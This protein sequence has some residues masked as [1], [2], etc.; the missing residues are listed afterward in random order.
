MT[1]TT[2]D[3]G[4]ILDGM[5]TAGDGDRVSVGDLVD[6]SGRH[7]ILPG[8]LLVAL[9]T[10]TPLSGIPGVSVVCGVTIALA[11]IQLLIGAECLWLPGRLRNLSLQ[12]EGV[13]RNVRRIRPVADWFDR[14]TR[15]RL[16]FLFHR[17]LVFVPEFLMVIAG[18]T[19]PFLENIPF[20]SSAMATAVAF[21]ALGLL[22]RDDLFAVLALIPFAT[23]GAL[24][25]IAFI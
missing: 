20:S 16:A 9:V 8:V 13:V 1:R 19:M 15:S 11:S 7:G 4:D 12:R 25:W 10:A 24:L 2:R 23:F 14:H 5:T 17:P 21:L 18:L 22:T 3:L 6:A